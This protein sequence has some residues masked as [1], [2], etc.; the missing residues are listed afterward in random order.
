MLSP[1]RNL[2]KV[3]DS[4]TMALKKLGVYTPVVRDLGPDGKPIGNTPDKLVLGVFD[5]TSGEKIGDFLT[6]HMRG[7]ELSHIS[8]SAYGYALGC[9]TYLKPE[10]TQQTLKVYLS[11]GNVLLPGKEATNNAWIHYIL[12]VQKAHLTLFQITINVTQR[13]RDMQLLLL[14]SASGLGPYL[15]Q[16][17][18]LWRDIKDS[19]TDEEV[20]AC[21][22][23]N[24]LGYDS[25]H[26]TMFMVTKYNAGLAVLRAQNEAARKAQLKLDPHS[27]PPV[28]ELV[29]TLWRLSATITSQEKADI[30]LIRSG[31]IMT[32]IAQP[33]LVPP[34]VPVA[35]AAPVGPS[36]PAGPP[37]R[38]PA[39]R[40]SGIA[41]STG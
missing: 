29:H 39:P 18:E 19:V 24:V 13:K 38:Q 34:R 12:A 20:A 17:M 40:T 10:A 4:E 15:D 2:G 33:G 25:R 9:G 31:A 3:H 26:D 21:V 7:A 27:L 23:A 35:P 16:L 8:A 1:E 5:P 30:D 11:A 14:N 22:I 36:R 37:Q 32:G 41:S 28:E 6:Q